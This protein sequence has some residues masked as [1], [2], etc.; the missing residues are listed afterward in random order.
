MSVSDL[1]L[2]TSVRGGASVRD[3]HARER[4]FPCMACV[5]PH[6]LALPVSFYSTRYPTSAAAF[7]PT[8]QPRCGDQGV[9]SV[10]AFARPRLVLSRSQLPKFILAVSAACRL[11]WAGRRG[12]PWKAHSPAPSCQPRLRPIARRS[13]PSVPRPPGCRPHRAIATRIEEHDAE[14]WWADA[15]ES[16]AASEHDSEFDLEPYQE[17]LCGSIARD[18][19]IHSRG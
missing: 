12:N 6:A 4:L 3:E 11:A 15:P 16:D 9:A 2:S 18:D 8:Q 19:V 7:L 5:S 17:E 1:R 10:S 13:L 14:C